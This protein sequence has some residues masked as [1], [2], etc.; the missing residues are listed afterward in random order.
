M[1]NIGTLIVISAPS[2]GGKTTVIRNLLEIVPDSARLITTTT[3]APREGEADAVD[4]HFLS[5]T[6]FEAKI[7]KGDFLE[8]VEYADHYYGTDKHELQSMLER[9]RYVFAAVEVRGKKSFE[10]AGVPMF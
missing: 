4:Y 8:Y 7:Q 6:E 5:K 2:G 1:N 10:S 3:R 9:Y